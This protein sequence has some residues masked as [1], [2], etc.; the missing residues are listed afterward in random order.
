MRAYLFAVPALL[1]GLTAAQAQGD[2]AI[3]QKLAQE[4]SNSMAQRNMMDH[5]GFE[6]R[7]R[8]GAKA[9]NVAYGAATKAGAMAMWL[10]SPPHLA[11]LL[12][13]GCR[14]VASAVSR[15]GVRYWTMEIAKTAT[16]R[17]RHAALH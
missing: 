9:E 8:R 15:S 14:G 4:H 16:V 13:P 10:A 3:M 1:L 5:A 2:C 7:A 11:N 12:L 6:E 17:S